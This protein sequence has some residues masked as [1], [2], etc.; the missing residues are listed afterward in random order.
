MKELNE[1]SVIQDLDASQRYSSLC[2]LCYWR[3]SQTHTSLFSAFHN[4]VTEVQTS[5]WG[6]TLEVI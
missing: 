6:V 3:P 2:R 4:N 1:G 5:E